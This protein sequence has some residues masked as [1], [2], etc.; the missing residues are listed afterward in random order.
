MVT[1]TYTAIIALVVCFQSILPATA[2]GLSAAATINE[3]NSAQIETLTGR[4]AKKEMEL[5]RLNSNF[6]RECTKVSKWKPWRLFFY[7][8]AASGS[9]NAGITHISA[10]RWHY[11]PRPRR[12]SRDTA[13]TGPTLL[14]IGHCITLGG[15]LTE[16]TLDRINDHKVKKKGFDIKTTHRRALEIKAELD[17]LLTERDAL[18]AKSQELD[19]AEQCLV[20][21]EG[22]VL[23]DVRDLALSEYMQFYVRANKFFGS[24]EANALMAVTAASTGGFQGSLLGM[25]SAAKRDPRLVGPGGLGFL[26]SG[27]TIVAT[28]VVARLS[29]NIRGKHARHKISSELDNIT[30]KSI[31]QLNDHRL[32][33][34]RLTLQNAALESQP[35]VS[36]R[37]IAYE[38]QATLFSAQNEMNAAEKRLGDKEFKERLFFASAI[39]GTKMSWGINLANAGY[40]FKPQVIPQLSIDKKTKKRSIK[41]V[42]DPSPARMFT[43]RVAVGSTTYIPGT[44]MWI[45]DTL[46]N[47]IRGEMRNRSLLADKTHPSILL[48]ERF[49][50][51][52]E[53]DSVFTY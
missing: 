34:S 23:K 48:K 22:L 2:A 38:K 3:T 40:R 13:K 53:I 8:L 45:L 9:S 14:L 20:Q 19:A 12:M 28:P 26:I 1:K 29:A 21:A 41:F 24:R 10:T 43:H 16:A 25:V 30:T 7:N 44:G 5:L 37:L 50:R 11:W 39:G 33:L 4:I 27:A 46:Q 52:D 42:A 31:D 49:D 6:R 47:R 51:L 32:A 18:V 35:K 17:S 36:K 15:V